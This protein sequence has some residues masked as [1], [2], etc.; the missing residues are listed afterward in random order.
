MTD[1]R[2]SCTATGPKGRRTRRGTTPAGARLSAMN[3]YRDAF[4]GWKKGDVRCSTPR[5]VTPRKAA[6][7]A[8]KG[9]RRD[10][11]RIEALTRTVEHHAAEIERLN[12]QHEQLIAL[13]RTSQ[14]GAEV[15]RELTGTRARATHQPAVV[16]SA[17]REVCARSRCN[18]TARSL[19]HVDR[20]GDRYCV[21]CAR[22][23]NEHA[24]RT[25]VPMPPRPTRRP[26]Q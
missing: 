1:K 15:A 4:G 17:P 24:G 13:L 6:A 26:G 23:I 18:R 12:R 7:R 16:T 21:A 9:T 3:A 19:D 5:V 10:R 11:E 22:R 8:P 20:P 2:W 14:A 25:L